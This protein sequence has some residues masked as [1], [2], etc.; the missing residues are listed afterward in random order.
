MGLDI[1]LFIEGRIDSVN[2]YFPK[3]IQKRVS[4]NTNTLFVKAEIGDFRKCYPFFQEVEKHL[5]REI[6]NCEYVDLSI[7][8]FTKIVNNLCRNKATYEEWHQ[9]QIKE[10]KEISKDLNSCINDGE[11]W[12]QFWAWW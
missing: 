5:G 8:D 12:L 6:I 3:K 2:E 4:E 1:S 10:L 9:E 11:Y 7:G